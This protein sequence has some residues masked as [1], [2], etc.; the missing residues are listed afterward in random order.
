MLA[1]QLV[2]ALVALVVG[3]VLVVRVLQP[4]VHTTALGAVGT[5]KLSLLET[6]QLLQ[7]AAAVTVVMQVARVARVA[8]QE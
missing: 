5:R 2:V 3:E 6:R 4:I 8:Q 1:G 7:G